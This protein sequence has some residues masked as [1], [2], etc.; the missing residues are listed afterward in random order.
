LQRHSSQ[1]ESAKKVKNW[2]FRRLLKLQRKE[3]K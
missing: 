1:G 2:S 3:K